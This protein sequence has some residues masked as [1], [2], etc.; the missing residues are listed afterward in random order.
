M[1]GERRY[2]TQRPDGHWADT[3]EG[4]ERPGGLYRTQ[5]D[6]EAAVTTHLQNRTGGGE[7]IH[8]PGGQIRISNTINRL[9]PDPPRDTKH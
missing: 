7:V 1:N 9:D 3:A 5:A 8:C 6:A 4:A 2:V